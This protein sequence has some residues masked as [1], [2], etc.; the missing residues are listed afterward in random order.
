MYVQLCEYAFLLSVHWLARLRFEAMGQRDNNPVTEPSMDQVQRKGRQQHPYSLTKV[1]IGTEDGSLTHRW[2]VQA[3]NQTALRISE[4]ETLETDGP[5]RRC[6]HVRPKIE[7]PRH[8][9]L[10]LLYSVGMFGARV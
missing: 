7:P 2:P 9:E 4:K 6:D 8:G 5:L 1:R 10:L 3:G